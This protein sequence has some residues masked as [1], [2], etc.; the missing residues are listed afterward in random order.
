MT[1]DA[2]MRYIRSDKGR[3]TRAAYRRSERGRAVLASLNRAYRA[4]DPDRQ[5]ARDAANRAARAGRLTK[6]EACSACGSSGRIEG[7]HHRGYAP[8]HMLDVVWLCNRCHR[9]THGRRVPE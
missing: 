5:R 6:P 3:A 1:P 9:L 4:A 2:V 7:H 8:E